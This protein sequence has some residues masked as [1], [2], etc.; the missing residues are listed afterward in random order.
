MGSTPGPSDPLSSSSLS[1]GWVASEWQVTVYSQVWWYGHVV[2]G[3]FGNLS[4]VWFKVFSVLFQSSISFTSFFFFIIFSMYPCSSSWSPPV[5]VLSFFHLFLLLSSSYSLLHFLLLISNFSFQLSSFFF[6]SSIISL[7]STFLLLSL[8]LLFPLA[9]KSIHRSWISHVSVRRGNE[10][11]VFQLQK[12][13]QLRAVY[14]EKTVYT[15]QVG[16]GC[17]FGALALMLRFYFEVT[18]VKLTYLNT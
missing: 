17:C 16:P 1:N 8:P 3:V 9:I 5:S 2:N 15:Q 4:L 12:M 18:I 13:R 14:P 7:Y 11:A 6:S 10:L